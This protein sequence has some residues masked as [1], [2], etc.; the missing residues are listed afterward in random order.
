M[1]WL[2]E[3]IA[4]VHSALF[5]S[6]TSTMVAMKVM[7]KKAVGVKALTKGNLKVMAH[8]LGELQ[9]MILWRVEYGP[10]LGDGLNPLHLGKGLREVR[11]GCAPC[12]ARA[13]HSTSKVERT[14][15]GTASA[16]L[17]ITHGPM[18]T[19]G[20]RRCRSCMRSRS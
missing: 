7:K 13:R 12:V 15:C 6:P 18:P 19:A 16:S 11:I 20:R 4:E 14:H 8:E 5:F 9:G 3:T 2:K 17:Q 1:F 10:F